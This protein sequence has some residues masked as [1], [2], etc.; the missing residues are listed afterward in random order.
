MVKKT[1]KPSKALEANLRE[2]I[3]VS[4]PG[5]P[6]GTEVALAKKFGVARMTAR[7]V[8]DRLCGEGLVVRRAGI[9]LFVAGT[10]R[11]ERYLFLAGNL[12]WDMA[13]KVAKGFR[14]SAEKRGAEVELFDAQG[15]EA[16]LKEA[17]AGL[18]DGAF[19]AA[20]VLS[21]HEAGVA[22]VVREMAAN[23]FRIVMI[24][25]AVEGVASVVSD[26]RLGGALAA[27]ALVRAGH[28]SLG[29]IGDL[30]ADTV[31]ARWEGFAAVAK[32]MN[33]VTPVKSDVGGVSRLGDWEAQVISAAKRIMKRK[34]KPSAVF[35]SCDAVARYAMRAF[36]SAGLKVP[37]DV[38]IVGFDDDPIAEWTSPALTTV[39][40]DFGRMGA[41]A[42]R[43]MGGASKTVTVPIEFVDRE[44]VRRLKG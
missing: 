29:F 25:E 7:N 35:C 13:M 41:E 30:K 1:L 37:G 6:L 31:L 20:A 16:R 4:E 33:G 12:L 3:G 21:T 24:D 27:E 10:A 39:K 38:S 42:A 23:G 9:G 19:S 2:T 40:Q 28:R 43:L 32:D 22:E 5:S 14:T 26:N 11:R 36:E 34:E 44:S 15:D 17:I 8:V 18:K